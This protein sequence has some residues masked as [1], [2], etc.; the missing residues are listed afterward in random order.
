[1]R[2]SP[3]L[4]DLARTARIY[5]GLLAA[6]YSS[7]LLPDDRAQIDAAAKA[8]S[9]EDQ[10]LAAYRLRG[11]AANHA[12]R[13]RASR[14]RAALRGQWINLFQEV[15][16]VLCPPMPSLASRTTTLRIAAVSSIW[17]VA[18]SPMTT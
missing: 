4:P 9:P 3:K 14:L 8:L 5:G 17:M 2:E 10:N 15:D 7:D 11:I 13:I 16:I 12:E 18:K 6:V 1:M